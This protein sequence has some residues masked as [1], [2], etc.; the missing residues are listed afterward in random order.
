V[1]SSALAALALYGAPNARKYRS[2]STVRI[3][4]EMT[5]KF[6]SSVRRH[7]AHYRQ[8]KSNLDTIALE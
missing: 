8:N 6:S 5:F 4:P 1:I 2:H 3:L 7:C